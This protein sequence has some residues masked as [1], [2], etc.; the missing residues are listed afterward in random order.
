MSRFE[1]GQLIGPVSVAISDTKIRL[2][3][4]QGRPEAAVLRAV[5]SDSTASFI[6][7]GGTL[8]RLEA[9]LTEVELR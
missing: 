6:G 1:P 2:Y 9:N 4:E 5:G 3:N 8:L 7:S